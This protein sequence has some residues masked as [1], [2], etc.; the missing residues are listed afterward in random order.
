MRS[1]PPTSAIERG[2]TPPAA[3]LIGPLT[4]VIPV[5]AKLAVAADVAVEL[6][7]PPDR[8]NWSPAAVET[9]AIVAPV[10]AMRTTPA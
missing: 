10:P 4:T 5:P 2:F 7:M 9:E 6:S 3:S 8:V 1:P